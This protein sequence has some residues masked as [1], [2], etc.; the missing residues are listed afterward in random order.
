MI[1]IRRGAD[2]PGLVPTSGCWAGPA[3]TPWHTLVADSPAT[4]SQWA[5]GHSLP[6]EVEE[7][8]TLEEPGPAPG[9]PQGSLESSICA[10]VQD[11]N[12]KNPHD[13]HRGQVETMKNLIDFKAA[14]AGL[15]KKYINLANRVPFF[16]VSSVHLCFL[17]II[18]KT[19]FVQILCDVLYCIQFTLHINLLNSHSVYFSFNL[20]QFSFM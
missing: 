6:S 12:K 8:Q 17:L 15:Q 7:Q 1:L 4:F 20:V 16:S 18:S 10:T 11:L 9:T 2:V 3:L 19:F 13:K 5:W 14:Y